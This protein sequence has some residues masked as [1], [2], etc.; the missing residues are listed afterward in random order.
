MT[1]RV[2]VTEAELRGVPFSRYRSVLHNLIGEPQEFDEIEVEQAK[3]G[4]P[5]V[6]ISGAKGD[7]EAKAGEI[8]KLAKGITNPR[9]I[10]GLFG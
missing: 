8:L 6:A 2:T 5:T 1:V 10:D 7:T 4:K 3:S 9:V